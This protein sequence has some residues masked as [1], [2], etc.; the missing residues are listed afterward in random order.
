MAIILVALVILKRHSHWC[1]LRYVYCSCN[2]VE[3]LETKFSE[4]I[5]YLHIP[6][7]RG[8]LQTFPVE[9]VTRDKELFF[10][11]KR[12]GKNFSWID[13]Q[14]WIP[15]IEVKIFGQFISQ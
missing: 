3:F 5:H 4:H 15:Q 9:K 7:V 10:L 14:N 13:N 11:V 2:F 1:I 6:L 8:Q 12:D